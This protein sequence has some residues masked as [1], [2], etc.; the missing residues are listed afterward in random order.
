MKRRAF[1]TACVVPVGTPLGG[2]LSDT[3]DR[4]DGTSDRND[5]DEPNGSDDAGDSGG[6][7]GTDGEDDAAGPAIRETRFEVCDV[8]EG[9]A[10]ESA[11]V[12]FE[13]DAITVVGIITGNNGCYTAR[14][15]N[16]RIDDNEVLVV[17]VESYEDADEDEMCTQAIVA[18]EYKAVVGIDGDLPGSVRVEHDGE[19]VTTEERP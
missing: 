19:H 7:A 12:T 3:S 11:S 16:A 5:T 13:D 4:D 9:E 18:I 8:G 15:A 2:C 10:G 6:G 14:I 1:L 17:A